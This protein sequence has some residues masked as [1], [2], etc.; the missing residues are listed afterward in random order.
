MGVSGEPLS[1]DEEASRQRTL[2]RGKEL[3]RALSNIQD[4]HIL[5]KRAVRNSL[6]HF[7]ER[8]DQYLFEA[9]EGANIFDRNIGPPGMI[10]ID[11]EIPRYL[12]HIDPQNSTITVLDV[13]AN[14]QNI[15]NALQTLKGRAQQ[16][17]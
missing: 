17:I 5:Q 16:L 13:D 2:A 1:T 15:M 3:R 12:R 9:G 8:L 10:Q 11:G 6:E 14:L 4:F 7:D